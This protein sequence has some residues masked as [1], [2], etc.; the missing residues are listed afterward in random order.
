MK[1][2]I[3]RGLST[4]LYNRKTTELEHEYKHQSI[5]KKQKQQKY[6]RE[7]EMKECVHAEAWE[8]VKA[9]RSMGACEGT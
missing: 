2:Y 9:C 4:R 1:K 6:Q 5:Q 7:R 3:V 8:H